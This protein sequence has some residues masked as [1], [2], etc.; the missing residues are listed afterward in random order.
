MSHECVSDVGVFDGDR[1]SWRLN[2]RRSLFQW[3][4][5]SVSNILAI[6]DTFRPSLAADKWWWNFASDGCF[7]VKS[8]FDSISKDLIDVPPLTTLEVRTFSKIWESPAP[9]K[10]IVFSWQL[11][12]DRVPTKSNL[13]ARGILS[14][15]EGANC[16]WCNVCRES[17]THLFLHCKVALGV[18]YE[19]FRWLG[20][21]VVMP[22]TLFHLFDGL[23]DIA[24]NSKVTNGFRLVWHTALWN[25]SLDYLEC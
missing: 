18:W 20:V 10:V 22:P 11:L 9:S 2:W 8:A 15:Q 13:L 19:L 12:Y 6:L 1:W 7:S 16:V 25:G 17:S 4:M 23:S 24:R 3:E 14:Q 5:D 21:V